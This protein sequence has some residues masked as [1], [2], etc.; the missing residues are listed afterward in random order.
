MKTIITRENI[1]Y[2]L[3]GVLLGILL[4]II[5]HTLGCLSPGLTVLAMENESTTTTS[6]TLN[7]RDQLMIQMCYN[8]VADMRES[9]RCQEILSQINTTTTN[10]QSIPTNLLSIV[11]TVESR[12]VTTRTQEGVVSSRL[13]PFPTLITTRP[14]N[15]VTT[16]TTTTTT[17][18]GGC[19]GYITS[20][21]GWNHTKMM[22][23]R[24]G[25]RWIK[26]HQNTTNAT[27]L[28]SVG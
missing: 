25:Y 20:G 13:N 22:M 14:T 2:Y 11:T 18:L 24:G 3:I 7:S 8:N 26:S 12:V 28:L 9:A 19:G 15:S 16:S 21:G 17:T 27:I 23:C 10:L 6:T 1:N 5:I 4:G